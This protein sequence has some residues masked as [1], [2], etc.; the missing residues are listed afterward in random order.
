MKKQNTKNLIWIILDG[1]RSAKDGNPKER[2]ESFNKT[3]SRGAFFQKVIAPAGSTMMSI[4]SFITGSPSYAILPDYFSSL[5]PS[6]IKSELKFFGNSELTI[7]RQKYPT[8]LDNLEE[9]D[10]TTSISSYYHSLRLFM[11]GLGVMMEFNENCKSKVDLLDWSNEKV[12]DLTKKMLKANQTGQ[13]FCL[14]IHYNA[15][16]GIDRIFSDTI[17]L[18][19]KK[20]FFDNGIL[21]FCPDHGFH[22]GSWTI[23]HDSDVGV[24]T[25]VTVGGL[26]GEGI[27][28]QVQ[29]VNVWGPDLLFTAFDLAGMLPN[30]LRNRYEY[31][32]R[33]Y[34]ES[35][36]T[37]E[38][39]QNFGKIFRF[40]SRFM[41]QPGAITAMLKDDLIW[42][43]DHTTGEIFPLTRWAFE[44]DHGVREFEIENTPEIQLL[45]RKLRKEFESNQKSILEYGNFAK[46]DCD[47]I[48]AMS[49]NLQGDLVHLFEGHTYKHTLGIEPKNAR[50]LIFRSFPMDYFDRSA[51]VISSYFTPSLVDVICDNISVPIIESYGFRPFCYGEGMVVKDSLFAKF[52][53]LLKGK[54]DICLVGYNSSPLEAYNNILDILDKI[55]PL[56]SYFINDNG[57]LYPIKD[58][59]EWLEGIEELQCIRQRYRELVYRYGRKNAL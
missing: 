42:R 52:P 58:Y 43:F 28:S 27:K 31:G 18:L 23:P 7:D 26:I 55:S 24:N 12:F 25:L 22:S 32:A 30:K 36:K 54:Y 14:I 5:M 44:F 4:I 37:G 35:I 59:K 11:R 3:V 41:K 51:K 34:R 40:D 45:K 46:K 21:L 50:V 15:K 49:A 47:S 1:M 33:S 6:A 2:F 13:K 20:R 48:Q 29:T 19:D 10:V 9:L 17:N 53:D 38:S 39:I 8:L 16:H 56:Y 57:C